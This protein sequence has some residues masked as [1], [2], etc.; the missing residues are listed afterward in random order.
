L[1][2]YL[3]LMRLFL[4]SLKYPRIPLHSSTIHIVQH[5]SQN[6]LFSKYYLETI[7]YNMADYYDLDD[8]HNISDEYSS[9]EDSDPSSR[10][11]I[12]V[13]IKPKTLSR[14]F[15][16]WTLLVLVV[17]ITIR[18]FASNIGEAFCKIPGIQDLHSV[19]PNKTRAPNKESPVLRQFSQLFTNA[20]EVYAEVLI[21]LH[22]SFCNIPAFKNF[23]L[24][25]S[26]TS[27]VDTNDILS[28]DTVGEAAE[29]KITVEEFA[30]IKEAA[31][32][33]EAEMIKSTAMIEEAATIEEAII[34]EAATIKEAENIKKAAIVQQAKITKKAVIRQETVIIKEAKIARDAVDKD[35]TA[36]T[37][38]VQDEPIQTFINAMKINQEFM[39]IVHLKD[40]ARDMRKHE[41]AVRHSDIENPDQIADL[42]GAC[43]VTLDT[44]IDELIYWVRFGNEL[45]DQKIVQ[46]N[47]DIEIVNAAQQRRRFNGR[48]EDMTRLLDSLKEYITKAELIKSQGDALMSTFSKTA[49]QLVKIEDE[50]FKKLERVKKQHNRKLKADSRW[51]PGID[52][53]SSFS[54]QIAALEMAS[55]FPIFAQDELATPFAP[56]HQRIQEILVLK[57]RVEAFLWNSTRRDMK[58]PLIGPFENV[59]PN[60]AKYND[61]EEEEDVSQASV[62]DKKSA[63]DVEKCIDEINIK[64][65]KTGVE[66]EADTTVDSNKDILTETIK[67][68]DTTT[69]SNTTSPNEKSS[70]IDAV[71]MQVGAHATHLERQFR[72]SSLAKGAVLADLFSAFTTKLADVAGDF[73]IWETAVF[74]NH[75]S[76]ASHFQEAN[77]QPSLD[78]LL[79]LSKETLRL[80]ETGKALSERLFELIQD[81]RNIFLAVEK[82]FEILSKTNTENKGFFGGLKVVFKTA[83]SNEAGLLTAASMFTQDIVLNKVHQDLYVEYLHHLSVQ[84]KRLR[85]L[86]QEREWEI[87]YPKAS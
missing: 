12:R 22:E 40:L 29:K 10:S 54:S 66:N 44:A 25:C 24:V 71:L 74:A 37:I 47:D 72:I 18:A 1:R 13:E 80:G 51:W 4:S 56:M 42:F 2:V 32:I 62:E 17:R 61:K 69:T 79:T 31:I 23:P 41:L 65:N 76:S 15:L 46:I 28:E 39:N 68:N 77:G 6:P 43:V 85:A 81:E 52:E 26:D 70:A 82:E 30:N 50:V 48:G 63:A 7:L 35:T 3:L 27:V 9:D 84:Q 11:Y 57:R 21:P 73:Y 14:G 67:S 36:Q 38:T 87:A 8:D 58:F 55:N 49:D 45:R 64:E 5:L 20:S 16:P 60:A 33:E 86:V 83:F 78:I 34:K 53:N 19:C 75:Q 59:L